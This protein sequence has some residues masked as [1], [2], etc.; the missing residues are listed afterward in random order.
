MGI[1]Q[2][3]WIPFMRSSEKDMEVL[4]Q[5]S[6]CGL[7]KE[8]HVHETCPTLERSNIAITEGNNLFTTYMECFIMTYVFEPFNLTKGMDSVASTMD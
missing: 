7:A 2:N 5:I 1:I 6:V 8:V 4:V 3:G